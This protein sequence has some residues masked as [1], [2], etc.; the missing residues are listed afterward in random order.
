[1]SHDAGTQLVIEHIE[2]YWAPTIT[3]DQLVHALK[4]SAS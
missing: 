4:E 2:K 1:V 3:S